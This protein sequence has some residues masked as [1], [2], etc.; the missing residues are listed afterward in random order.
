M[1]IDTLNITNPWDSHLT[2]TSSPANILP[3]GF[4][5]Y[6]TDQALTCQ[7]STGENFSAF[8]SCFYSFLESQPDFSSPHE[9]PDLP[10]RSVSP[11][12]TPG[13]RTLHPEIAGYDF[14]TGHIFASPIWP[15]DEN[16]YP[17]SFELSDV[18]KEVETP[19][20]WGLV[21]DLESF[22]QAL[23]HTRIADGTSEEVP[24][25]HQ[26]A[27][28]SQRKHKVKP[29]I[30]LPQT[31]QKNSHRCDFPGCSRTFRRT[32]HLKRHIKT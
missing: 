19:P 18:A 14:H 7:Y 24:R 27:R 17:G 21:D 13:D 31:L 2:P 12:M 30:E 23:S 3:D 4:T 6:G 10:Q 5:H 20:R 29:V 9:L 32:E 16:E 1:R 8:D 26:A 15:S 28:R 22:G 25:S 11:L